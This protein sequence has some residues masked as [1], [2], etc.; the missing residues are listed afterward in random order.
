MTLS[1]MPIPEELPP[2]AFSEEQALQGIKPVD[3]STTIGKLRVQVRFGK[4]KKIIIRGT[5]W[6][7]PT[8]G[9]NDR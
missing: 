1:V 5:A 2:G 8:G 7:F 6:Y 3:I 9:A 4:L